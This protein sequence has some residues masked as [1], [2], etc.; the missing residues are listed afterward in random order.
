MKNPET[1]AALGIKHWG[2]IYKT[3]TK[4]KRLTPTTTKPADRPLE[5]LSLLNRVVL[6][7]SWLYYKTS[8][9]L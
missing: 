5:I 3:K 7:G 9:I 6:Y 1:H 8:V 4:T 2:K